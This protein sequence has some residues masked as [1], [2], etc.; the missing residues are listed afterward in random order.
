MWVSPATIRQRVAAAL[1]GLSG[2][3]ESPV[4]FDVYTLRN[5]DSLQHRG[6][7]VGIP[8]TT[9][10]DTRQRGKA[11]S[12]TQ[13]VVRWGYRIVTDGQVAAGDAA[14]TDELAAIAAI[15]TMDESEVGRPRLESIT[16]RT[17]G[18]PVAMRLTEATFSVDHFYPLS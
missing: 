12:T 2:W 16:R 6:F 8:S 14:T 17:S 7:A 11:L 4:D 5:Y 15:R 13:V 1:A 9:T 10:S 3:S 18:E